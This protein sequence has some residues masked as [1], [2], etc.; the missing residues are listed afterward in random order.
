MLLTFT[1]IVFFASIFLIFSQEF[2]RSGKKIAAIPG[3]KLL[4]PLVM[5]SWLIEAYE[6]WG[7]WLLLWAQAVFHQCIQ[8][9]TDLLPFQSGG[10]HL[11]RIMTIFLLACLPSWV[12]WLRAKWKDSY[13]LQPCADYFGLAIWITVVFLLIIKPI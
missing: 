7:L 5:L 6:D 9:M 11:V 8:S 2:I 10:L 3:V 4:V 12:F 1:G 13:K